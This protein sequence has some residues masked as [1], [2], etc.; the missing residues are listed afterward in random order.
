[1]EPHDPALDDE[2]RQAFAAAAEPVQGRGVRPEAIRAAVARR[3]RTRRLARY[4]TVASLAGAAA[5][6]VAFLMPRGDD[7]ALW[8]DDGSTTSTSSPATTATT[9]TPDETTSTTDTTATTDPTEGP[10]PPSPSSSSSSTSSSSTTSSTEAPPLPDFP[11][12]QLG[13]QNGDRTW[14]LYLVIEREGEDR[15]AD[16]TA[17]NAAALEAGYHPNSGGGNGAPPLG[18]DRGALEAFG[19]EGTQPYAVGVYFATR[20]VAEQAQAAFE[21]RGVSTAGIAE[22]T[23]DCRD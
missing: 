18:C 2:L 21:G 3:R 6:A 10:L 9:D 5:L 1:M 19:L 4:T 15:R 14:G 23:I 20:A 16:I 8:T 12:Q 13:L 17:A 22:V 7:G 11:P